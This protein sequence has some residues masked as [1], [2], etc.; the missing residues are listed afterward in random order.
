MLQL[1]ARATQSSCLT[2]SEPMVVKLT[3]NPTFPA[4]L[5]AKAAFLF[6]GQCESI[7][8][9]FAAVLFRAGMFKAGDAPNHIE[10]SDDQAFLSDR[11]VVRLFPDLKVTTLYRRNAS[12]NAL[13][14]TEQ[15][16]SYCVMCS[17][18]PKPHD[19]SQLILE[20]L[21][22][23]PLIDEDC[24]ELMITG[25]EPTLMGDRFFQLVSEIRALLPSTAI[26]V[27]T[28]GRNFKNPSLA[29]RLAAIK[30]RDLM[31][32]I[33]LYSDVPAIHDYVVQAAGAFDETIEGL[34]N[35]ASYGVRIELRVV[36]HKDTYKRLPRL[37]EFI[38]RNLQ[39]VD[40]V[41]LMGLELMGFARANLDAIWI[42]P[43]D[44][45]NELTEACDILLAGRVRPVIFNHQLCILPPRVRHLA[46]KSISDWK[47]EYMP[48]CDGCLEKR[49]GCG[50][51][52]SS[53]SI[54]HSMHITP[55]KDEVVIQQ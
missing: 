11:D 9:G 48:E 6:E 25:G 24:R 30:H 54:R 17:Q 15:C 28:N 26:H 10:L 34:I 44:Y 38:V 51:F 40:Q 14:V 8:S 13:L 19:D 45:Q 50:G 16:N 29:Q 55:F 27:L 36:I 21:E 23:L 31:L 39:F 12:V 53:A 7:P 1:R 35:L 18:P 37:A 49:R 43:F 22:A 20:W 4:A 42:D 32:G 46:V 41:S 3:T 47:N 5:R 33:P 2:F 52:F